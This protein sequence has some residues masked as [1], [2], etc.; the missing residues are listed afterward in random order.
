[1]LFRSLGSV[2]DGLAIGIL[3]TRS[4]AASILTP[5]MLPVASLAAGTLAVTLALVT[6]PGQRIAN[7]G[8][9]APANRPVIRSNLKIFF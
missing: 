1:M 2:V 9:L 4:S 3:S 7:V 6:A 8:G 5:V